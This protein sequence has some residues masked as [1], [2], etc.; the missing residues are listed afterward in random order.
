MGAAR[1]ALTAIM[2]V[3]G[4]L[5]VLLALAGSVLILEW[6]SHPGGIGMEWIVVPIVGLISLAFLTG[7]G[8]L[9]RLALMR[10]PRARTPTRG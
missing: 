5:L 9:L 2:L 4:G 10:R 8:L 1:S 7:G 3:G 6:L